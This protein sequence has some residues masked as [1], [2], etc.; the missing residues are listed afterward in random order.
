MSNSDQKI[1]VLTIDDDES[2]RL[3]IVSCLEDFGYFV[4]Q[5]SGGREGIESFEKYRPD[6]V[7]TDLNMPNVGGLVV[8]EEITR[9]SPDTPVVIVSGNDDAF[10]VAEAFR[11]GASGYITKPIFDFSVIDELIVQ[12]LSSAWEIKVEK[13]FNESLARC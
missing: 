1:S 13:R 7:F 9:L 5:A 3:S 6:F 4:Y 11:K 12:K 2:V 10:F 8:V